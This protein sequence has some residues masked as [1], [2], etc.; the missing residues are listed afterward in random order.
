MARPE[1]HKRKPPPE[2]RGVVR[3]DA[4]S[5][6]GDGVG[7]LDGKRV[8]VPLSAPGDV[9]DV[10]AKGE[11]GEVQELMEC[12]PDRVAPPCRHYGACGGCALQHLSP[13]F[14][15]DWK[16]ARVVDA[17]ARQGL[18]GALVGE[19]IATPQG[20]RRRA[21][22]A[23]RVK[24]GHATF[25]FNARKSATIVDLD[26]C[27]ILAP[28]L[29]AR[30]PQLRALA[31]VFATPSLDVAVTACENGL[32]VAV[33]AKMASPIAPA[34]AELIA[35]A[36]AAGVI[37]L[38]L[39]GETIVQFASPAISFDGVPATPPPG[40]FLQASREGEA[41]LIAGVMEA[42]KGARKIVDLF[43]GCGT[44][45]LPLAGIATVSAYDAGR[46]AIE[47]L[48]AAAAGAQRR[49]ASINPVNTEV[50]D[51]FERPLGA[52]EL[53]DFDAI[54]FDPPRA[55]A[56]AQARQ[57][58]ASSVR[59]VAAVSCNP[60]TFARD[61]AILVAGGYNLTRATPVDQ[62]VHSTHVEIVGAFQ[63]H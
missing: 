3:I 16:R 2:R 1:S 43:C 45:S 18:D 19:T 55:G 21:T 13:Q 5:S 61:A 50:R 12:G 23:A 35:A 30:L 27:V 11:R 4:V 56:E 59:R 52:K 34:R 29:Q 63:R 20:A 37:R 22:F 24:G 38:S 44:F 7:T 41:A 49:G 15:L 6:G 8:Y 51:L 17:L 54:V 36:Q 40:A 9:A 14:Q 42:T 25:G 62:F 32:D 57:I 33:A 58:A 60:T 26:E 28:L 10:L 39:N 48:R 31:A 46:D 47:T 53:K